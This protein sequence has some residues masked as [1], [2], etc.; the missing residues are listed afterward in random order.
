[1]KTFQV[2]VRVGEFV[3]GRGT[4]NSKKQA[5]QDAAANALGNVELNRRVFDEA[6]S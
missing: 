3:L 4:G 5:E 6:F 2:E 1:M